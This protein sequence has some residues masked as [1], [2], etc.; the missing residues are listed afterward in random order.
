[1]NPNT[2]F[3]YT[4]NLLFKDNL[5]FKVLWGH[6]TLPP[7]ISKDVFYWECIGGNDAVSK[8]F[9]NGVEWVD[10]VSRQVEPSV[11]RVYAKDKMTHAEGWLE[12]HNEIK[13]MD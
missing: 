6:P 4:G 5:I 7:R 13:M 3:P 10:G 9:Q 11:L 2:L 8:F 1:M 12:V